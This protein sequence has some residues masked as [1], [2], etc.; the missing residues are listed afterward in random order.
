VVRRHDR[1][2]FHDL[3]RHWHNGELLKYPVS[4]VLAHLDD[5][6]AFLLRHSEIKLGH[7]AVQP[8]LGM[9]TIHFERRLPRNHRDRAQNF[10]HVAP[11]VVGDLYFANLHRLNLVAL[12]IIRAG[13]E[14][15]SGDLPRRRALR[16]LFF[17]GRLGVLADLLF[18]LLDL[19]LGLFEIDHLQGD[20]LP[21]T[22]VRAVELHAV[23]ENLVL[24]RQ[25]IGA[26]LEI[27]LDDGSRG[28]Q[29][30]AR[31][32]NCKNDPSPPAHRSPPE[33]AQQ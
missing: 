28:R 2:L 3:F 9:Q 21:F 15:H 1:G 31:A 30:Q 7:G 6:E 19:G 11:L 13:L 10:P 32:E 4:V 17:V 14:R 27:E 8:G 25:L 23:R 5:R 24:P 18:T 12:H 20:L 22:A 16:L 29:A 26:V 33:S